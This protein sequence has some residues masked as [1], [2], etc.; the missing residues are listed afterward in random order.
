[1]PG[2]YSGGWGKD[3]GQLVQACYGL[4]GQCGSSVPSPGGLDLK[5]QIL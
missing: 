5:E 1:M 3:I 2:G 4:E